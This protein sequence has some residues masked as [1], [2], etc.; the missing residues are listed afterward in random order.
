MKHNSEE[1]QTEREQMRVDISFAVITY[2]TTM[3][4]YHQYI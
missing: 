1:M 3:L 4:G 2:G